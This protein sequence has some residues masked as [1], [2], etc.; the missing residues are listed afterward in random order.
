[1]NNE[2]LPIWHKAFIYLTIAGWAAFGIYYGLAKS[3]PNLVKRP[4]AAPEAAGSGCASLKAE[5]WRA[6]LY[7]EKAGCEETQELC[8]RKP[9]YSPDE[10]AEALACYIERMKKRYNEKVEREAPEIFAAK[11]WQKDGKYREAKRREINDRWIKIAEEQPIN[12]EGALLQ[13]IRIKDWSLSFAKA[14]GA[15][16][17]GASLPNSKFIKVDL[18]GAVFARAALGGA[19][20][21]GAKMKGTNLVKADLR[22]ALLTSVD[23]EDADFT[24]AKLEGASLPCGYQELN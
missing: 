19:E 23:I 16:F 5:Q 18:S 22:W 21:V 8:E 15:N 24:G 2:E 14:A 6:K 1:M 3:E 4:F 10:R 9:K 7:A 13:D 17:T 12:I 11:G 20:F